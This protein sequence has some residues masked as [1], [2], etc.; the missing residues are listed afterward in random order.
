M[1]TT[2]PERTS[3]YTTI[4]RTAPERA[5]GV[6]YAIDTHAAT[7]T[8][9]FHY[10]QPEGHNVAATGS[11]RHY[12]DASLGMGSGSSLI[13]WGIALTFNSGFTEVDPGGSVLF[14]VVFPI[15]E[16][17][18][19][20]VKEPRSAIDINL[21]RAS[22]GFSPAVPP[23]ATGY[24]LVASDGGVFSF[25]DA[26]FFGSTGNLTLNKP[27][28]GMAATP[29]GGGYWLVAS[30]GGVFSFGDPG[31]FGSTG[32]LSLNHPVVGMKVL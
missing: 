13:G 32:N 1:A 24:W 31:F 18:Y 15:G 25:G 16:W 28:V 26:G 29:D 20:A 27:V 4:K 17:I 11:F 22:A 12:P 5:R 8:L 7:A 3:P 14:D 30:D 2:T 21:L 10:N 6:E 23:S 9:D 19:R